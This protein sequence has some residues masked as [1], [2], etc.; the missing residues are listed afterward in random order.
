MAESQP[1]PTTA[2]V[3]VARTL[4]PSRPRGS[5][6]VTGLPVMASQTRAL[7]S[8]PDVSTQSPSG[9]KVAP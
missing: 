8:L 3:L 9:V 4:N 7:R 2:C 6:G 5:H 1:T